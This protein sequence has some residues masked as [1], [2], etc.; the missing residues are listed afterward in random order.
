[1]P[2]TMQL[3]DKALKFQPAARW[4]D[5]LDLSGLHHHPGAQARPSQPHTRRQ[6]R[7]QL[8]EDPKEWVTIAAMEAEPDSTA[9][10]QLL[11]RIGTTIRNM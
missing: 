7:G 9:K 6:H 2:T 3:L 8:G 5:A 11:K 10:R 4:A 1:M